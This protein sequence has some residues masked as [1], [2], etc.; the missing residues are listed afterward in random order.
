[1]LVAA[2]PSERPTRSRTSITSPSAASATLT[3]MGK[4]FGPSGSYGAGGSTRASRQVTAATTRT[5]VT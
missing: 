1:M 3:P 2:R 5:S 4:A